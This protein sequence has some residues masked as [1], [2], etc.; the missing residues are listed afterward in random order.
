MKKFFMVVYAWLFLAVLGVALA[1]GADFNPRDY[2]TSVLALGGIVA[3]AMAV[4]RTLIP[5][6]D[7]AAR[8]RSLSIVIGVILAVIGKAFG[9]FEGPYSEA[10]VFGISAGIGGITTVDL[11]RTI[12]QPRTSSLVAQGAKRFILDPIN[13]VVDGIAAAVDAFFPE[14]TIY[15]EMIKPIVRSLTGRINTQDEQSELMS[16]VAQDLHAFATA[17][18]KAEDPNAG[19]QIGQVML[20]ELTIKINQRFPIKGV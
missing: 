18:K 10:I 17:I 2:F 7:G 4:L 11:G 13:R 19:K 20:A 16:L 6:I 14:S 1:Q 15:W 8:V 9:W 12:T 5:A 3:G